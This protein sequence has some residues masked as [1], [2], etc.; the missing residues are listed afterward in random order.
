MRNSILGLILLGLLFAGCS[1]GG[2]G[3]GGES[4]GG[5]PWGSSVLLERDSMV[6]M[7]SQTINYAEGKNLRGPEVL[8]ELEKGFEIE[9]GD[10]CVVRR[11]KGGL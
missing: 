2:G 7:I 6:E 3:H 5:E 9:C 4:E 1:D 8:R 10:R 11:K